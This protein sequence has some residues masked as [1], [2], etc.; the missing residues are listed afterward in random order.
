MQILI[1]IRRKTKLCI[2]LVLQENIQLIVI[3]Y[4]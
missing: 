3:M 4:A 2:Y 1:R